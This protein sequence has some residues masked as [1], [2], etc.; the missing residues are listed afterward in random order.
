MSQPRYQ[1]I[2]ADGLPVVEKG[3]A[4]SGLWPGLGVSLGR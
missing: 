1:E 2:A 4:R 3:G